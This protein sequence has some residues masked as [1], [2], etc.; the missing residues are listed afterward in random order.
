VS[1]I[2]QAL[3]IQEEVGEYCGPFFAVASTIHCRTIGRLP[4]KFFDAQAPTRSSAFW[5]FSIEL[6]TLKRK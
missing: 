4:Y 2:L 6:A 1:A 5:I 3:L